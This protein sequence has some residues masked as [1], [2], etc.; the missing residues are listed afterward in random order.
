MR[1]AEKISYYNDVI[2]NAMASQITDVSVVYSTVGSGT[3]EKKTSKLRVPGLE[4]NLPGT[5]EFPA[6]KF[7]NAGNVS[8]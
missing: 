4:G 1:S 3:D 5:G 6:Q 2:I 8:I 7:S